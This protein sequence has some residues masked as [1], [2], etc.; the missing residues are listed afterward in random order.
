[1]NLADLFGWAGT[2]TGVLL[3]LP[4]LVRLLR[5]RNVDGLSVIAWQA[6]LAVNLGWT[7]HGLRIGQPP[8]WIT[9]VLSLAATVPILIL[10]ARA[11]QRRL[12]PV[13]LPGIAFAA[14]MVAVDIWWGSAAYG[15]IAIIPAVISNIGQSVELVRAPHVQGVSVLFLILAVANQALWLTWAILVR[16]PGTI[17]AAVTN[18]VLGVFNLSWYTA[19]RLGLPPA[20]VRTEKS[21]PAA[22]RTANQKESSSCEVC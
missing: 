10:L 18:G 16:D 20:F 9:S 3:G 8:Q 22:A 5:T 17:I 2:V 12:L 6:M 4:Q 19:R 1:M 14:V 11:L 7:V 15:V 13:L 21:R